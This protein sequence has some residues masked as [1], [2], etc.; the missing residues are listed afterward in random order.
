MEG[1]LWI[2]TRK[3]L[4][5]ATRKAS[6]WRLESEAFLGDPVT[7]CLPDRDGTVYA[8]LDHGHFG[9]KLHRR[10][11]GGSWLE[12][13]V[14]A[15]PEKP[16]G[17]SEKTPFGQEMPW[18]LKSIWSLE[19]GGGGREGS[20]WCGTIPGGLFR[21]RDR[22]ESWS[23]VDS[24]WNHPSRRNW[25]GGGADYPGVHSIAVDPRSSDRVLIAVSCGGVWETTDD[26]ESWTARAAGMRAH[27]MPPDK[28]EDP[29]IQ[30]P[31]CMV[32]CL[33]DPDRLWVQHHCGIWKSTDGAR[34]WQEI[35]EA[36][37]STFGFAVAVHPLDANTAWFVPAESDQRRI[38]VDG[39]VVV[40]RTRDGGES[41]EVLREGLPQHCAYDL[42]YRHALSVDDTGDRLAF[43]TT[44]GSLWV[45]EDQGDSWQTL[46]THLP[47]VYAVRFAPYR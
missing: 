30:D 5:S 17:H 40:T 34:S 14:P 24:L 6:G 41:F 23:L 39:Q 20:L 2:S 18:S 27:F 13:A 9:T 22:G 37:P 4:F 15:Y 44:T 10:Q 43:G 11:K 29:T 45:S 16:E 8:A 47:P 25:F 31:H 35:S 36:G 1:T 32:A 26:G 42:T 33:A 19:G 46:S 28:Q 3:G 38:P 7:Y 21:S 12:I